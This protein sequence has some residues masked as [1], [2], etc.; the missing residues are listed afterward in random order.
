[1]RL[2]AA[3]PD[4]ARRVWEWAND[5]ATRQASFASDRID[6]DDH[7]IWF[8][9]TLADEHRV[10]L[11]A[12]DPS[13]IG[14]VRFDRQDDHATIS[15]NLAPDCRGRGRGREV[16]EAATAWFQ[17]RWP[18]EVIARIKPTNRASIRAFSA[19]GYRLRDDTDDAAQVVYVW[20]PSVEKS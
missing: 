16:I 13:P 15:V 5:P 8:E 10:L 12:C 19:A 20:S 11:I 6:W 3:E 17:E 9:H 4:D 7:L 14:M 2:R 18:A 1:M